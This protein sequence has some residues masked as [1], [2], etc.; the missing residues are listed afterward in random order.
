MPTLAAKGFQFTS[1]ADAGRYEFTHCQHSS[2]VACRRLPGMSLEPAH[3]GGVGTRS[4]YINMLDFYLWVYL[5]VVV[6]RGKLI[7][8]HELK[9]AIETEIARVPT[10]T[11][12]VVIHNFK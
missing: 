4:P 9:V 11:C 6:Y 8:L 3:R 5:K 1:N 7:T 2:G 12:K 10:E